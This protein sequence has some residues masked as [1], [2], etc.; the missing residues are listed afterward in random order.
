MRRVCLESPFAGNVAEN[1]AYAK[2]AVRDCLARGEAPIAS[3][4]LFTQDGILR[5][6]TPAERELGI[7]AGLAWQEAADAVVVYQDRGI[8]GGMALAIDRAK[9]YNIPV[10]YRTLHP[11]TEKG[12][13]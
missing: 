2:A 13:Q 12:A 4:L 8:S 5:D 1:I 9:F 11:H 6:D 7:K 10:E 3:H